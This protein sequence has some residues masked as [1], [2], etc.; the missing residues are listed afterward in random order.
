MAKENDKTALTD[1]E[2]VMCYV[3]NRH[4]GV[5]QDVLAKLYNTNGGRVSEAVTAIE[6][7][8][9]HTKLVYEMAKEAKKEKHK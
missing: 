2:K 3:A 4:D 6:F 5:D 8:V 1:Y 7:A 9:I